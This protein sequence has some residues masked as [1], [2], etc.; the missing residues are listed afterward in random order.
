MQIARLVLVAIKNNA[1]RLKGVSWLRTLPGKPK[2][3]RQFHQKSWRC[4]NIYQPQD[5]ERTKNYK[6]GNR[7]LATNKTTFISLHENIHLEYVKFRIADS[8]G[9]SHRSDEVCPCYKLGWKQRRKR[10]SLRRCHLVDKK[11]IVRYAASRQVPD[12]T[13]YPAPGDD[14]GHERWRIGIHRTAQGT[15]LSSFSTRPQSST[16]IRKKF[17]LHVTLRKIWLLHVQFPF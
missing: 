13:V 16:F 6:D 12:T 8:S 9:Y 4:S 3:A 7:P 11:R 15:F 5:L 17:F 10:G 2:F 1:D 14:T